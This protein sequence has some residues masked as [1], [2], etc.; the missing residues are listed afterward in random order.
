MR[1]RRQMKV[2]TRDRSPARASKVAGT[3]F[4][5]ARLVELAL[6]ADDALLFRPVGP[7]HHRRNTE[8]MSLIWLHF[9]RSHRSLGRLVCTLFYAMT[10]QFSP[11][12]DASVH[13][14]RTR[15]GDL[16]QAQ[17]WLM[18]R[19]GATEGKVCQ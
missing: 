17:I 13:T 9:N 14:E 18:A 2:E 10:R 12:F 11:P 16:Y 5:T 6:S 3:A 4:G 15:R 7:F 19:P 8:P 1:S